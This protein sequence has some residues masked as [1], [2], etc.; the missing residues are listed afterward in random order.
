[1]V[2]VTLNARDVHLNFNDAGINATDG[3]AEGLVE[4]E[5]EDTL[6]AFTLADESEK[7]CDGCHKGGVMSELGKLCKP[8]AKDLKG[9]GREDGAKF[10]KLSSADLANP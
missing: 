10:A 2:L 6:R 3:G 1:M 7:D 4:H 5:R 8:K 9:R